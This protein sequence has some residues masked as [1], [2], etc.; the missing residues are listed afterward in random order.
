MLY[1]DPDAPVKT[2]GPRPVF[3]IIGPTETAP[4]DIV[5]VRLEKKKDHRKLPVAVRE[6]GQEPTSA[7]PLTRQP[8]STL[9]NSNLTAE[10][11]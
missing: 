6:D 11:A 4:R 1:R 10:L 2:Q 3:R 9:D 8:P 7:I 5:I